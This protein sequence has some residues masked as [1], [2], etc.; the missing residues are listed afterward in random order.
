MKKI[1]PFIGASI[2][3]LIA[4]TACNVKTVEEPVE[5]LEQLKEIESLQLKLD[6]TEAQLLN[7]R[8][9][10]AICKGDSSKPTTN[11]ID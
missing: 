6:A 7:I 1:Y 9:E 8:S 4:F 2:F 5:N 11:P 10:L 3:L